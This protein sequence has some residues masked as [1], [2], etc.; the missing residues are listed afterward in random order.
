[1]AGACCPSFNVLVQA[2]GALVQM[3][4]TPLWTQVVHEA[5]RLLPHTNARCPRSV[6]QLL[7][8]RLQLSPSNCPLR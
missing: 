1:M 8:S 2:L 7:C 4:L 6:P 5:L 3:E